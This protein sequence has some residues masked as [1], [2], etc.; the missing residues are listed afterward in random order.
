MEWS[1]YVRHS[2]TWR[3]SQLRG[4]TPLLHVKLLGFNQMGKALVWRCNSW[5]YYFDSLCLS[6]IVQQFKH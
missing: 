3:F 4:S 5:C 1:L 2:N 6:A